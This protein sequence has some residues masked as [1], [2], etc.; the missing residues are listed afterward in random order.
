MKNQ[1]EQI[2]RIICG[3][4][5]A[6]SDKT[7]DDKDGAVGVAIIIAYLQGV[8]PRL[9][10]LARAIDLPP[11]L[12][13]MAYRRLQ[14]NG[15]FSPRSWILSDRA[16]TAKGGMNRNGTVSESMYAWCYIAGMASG[17]TG[18]GFTRAEC[19]EMYGQSA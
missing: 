13:E 14:M 12:V 2:V 4:D 17:Y 8:Q 16:L 19:D 1:Y 15:I 3:D 10:D 7:Q 18:K 9:L 11:Y 5:W 6:G